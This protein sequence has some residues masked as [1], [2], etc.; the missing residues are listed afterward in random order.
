MDVSKTL[1][2]RK[3]DALGSELVPHRYSC[4]D[5]LCYTCVNFPPD[6]RPVALCS[7]RQILVVPVIDG[8]NCVQYQER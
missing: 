6:K 3:S 8:R 7:V 4:P 5:P 1:N 2:R